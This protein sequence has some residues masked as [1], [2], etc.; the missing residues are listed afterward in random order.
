MPYG[1]LFVATNQFPY[2]NS[3]PYLPY[4]YGKQNSRRLPMPSL[5]PCSQQFGALPQHGIDTYRIG[6]YTSSPACRNVCIDGIRDTPACRRTY[7]ERSVHACSTQAAR[8]YFAWNSQEL[9]NAQNVP[10]A[11]LVQVWLQRSRQTPIPRLQSR[12]AAAH[13]AAAPAAA[14]VV[15]ACATMMAPSAVAATMAAYPCFVPTSALAEPRGPQAKRCCRRQ[16]KDNDTQR[17]AAQQQF[18]SFVVTTLQGLSTLSR[19]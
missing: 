19:C 17:L 14:D 16:L 18:S 6:C 1:N 10:E 12:L 4:T 15:A 3:F 8:L 7:V 5:T 2:G 9:L 11:C 13:A